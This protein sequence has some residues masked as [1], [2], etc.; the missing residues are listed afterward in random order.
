MQQGAERRRRRWDVGM[1]SLS[2]DEAV[3]RQLVVTAL[4]IKCL[5]TARVT[6]GMEAGED[7]PH[8]ST[9][10]GLICAAKRLR[11]G[12]KVLLEWALTQ[13]GVRAKNSTRSFMSTDQTVRGTAALELV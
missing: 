10:N 2:S 12:L 6:E 3:K 11:N 1:P 9:K 8:V 5:E 4:I 13:T 7:S